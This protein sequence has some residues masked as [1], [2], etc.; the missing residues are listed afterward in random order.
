MLAEWHV[1]DFKAENSARGWRVS[2]DVAGTPVWVESENL[3]LRAVPEGFASPFVLAAI[4]RG[5]TIRVAAP[6]SAVWLS[7]MEKL[8]YFYSR[9][10][11]LPFRMP[12]A[13]EK[14][15]DGESCPDRGRALFFS[16]GV[17]AFYTLMNYPERLDNLLLVQGFDIPLDDDTRLQGCRK[18]LDEVARA[19]GARWSLLRSNL[20][21]HPCLWG[22]PPYVGTPMWMAS[23]GHM[24]T[25]TF[26]EFVMSSGCSFEMVDAK[27]AEWFELP[28]LSSERARWIWYGYHLRRIAKL[29][30]LAKQP[31]VRE[32]LR[33]CWKTVVPQGNCSRCEKCV[34]TMTVLAAF[35]ELQ[36]FG[37]VFDLSVP[38][39]DRISSVRL[40]RH[41]Q[42]QVWER[43][44]GLDLPSDVKAAV[45]RMIRRSA[46]SY[47]LCMRRRGVFGGI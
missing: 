28:W 37:R 21:A 27:G 12:I 38:L 11:K 44:A 6:V 23:L 45:R 15:T 8:A 31:L 39:V 17:D 26:D 29:Q 4:Y 24:L 14:T 13:A 25:D 41:F 5:A 2:A 36:N 1:R 32:Y 7:N 42:F 20:Y 16:G 22:I 33:V 43:I 34:R 47:R 46:L 3:P 40:R 9:T 10:W 19:V 18:M 35:G 30:I